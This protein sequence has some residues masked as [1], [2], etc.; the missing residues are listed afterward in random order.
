MFSKVT[1]TLIFSFIA[2][3]SQP[4]YS[5]QT[6]DEQLSNFIEKKK[7]HNTKIKNGYSVILYS[8]KEEKARETYFEFKS[9]FEDIEIQLTYVSPDW[10]VATIAYPS[11]IE[12]ERKLIIIK[13]KFPFAKPL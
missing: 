1:F 9:E 5:Q 6:K 4:S 13:E 12:A 3:S 2:F 8:G 7:N 10:K 11:K